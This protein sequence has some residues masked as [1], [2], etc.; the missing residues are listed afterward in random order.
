MKRS[1]LLAVVV[2]SACAS[3]GPPPEPPTVRTV[4]ATVRG[5]GG[6]TVRATA[7]ANTVA[8][9]TAVTVNLAGGTSGSSHPW[10]IHVGRCETNGPIFGAASAYPALRPDGSG[11]ATATAMLAVELAATESYYVN[12]HE[13]PQNLGRII[14]CG[15]LR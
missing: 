10:H 2:V 11:S 1:T 6:S 8:G 3:Q 5:M 4:N 12:I 9:Q 15:D 14:G 13:S 7:Q